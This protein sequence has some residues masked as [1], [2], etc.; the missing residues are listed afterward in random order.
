MQGRR[1]SK[2]LDKIWGL[3]FPC[4]GQSSGRGKSTNDESLTLPLYDEND[5]PEHAWQL[6]VYALAK[7]EGP[8]TVPVSGTC[9]GPI[10]DTLALYLLLYFPHPSA[11]HWFPSLHQVHAYPNV[12]LQESQLDD[13]KSPSMNAP[14]S[15]KWG[16]L[17]RRVK[18]IIRIARGTKSRFLLATA[19]GYTRSIYLGSINLKSARGLGLISGQTYTLLDLTPFYAHQV[20]AVHDG[21]QTTSRTTHG[22]RNCRDAFMPM[23]N[24]NLI[25]VCRELSE[26]NPPSPGNSARLYQY[27]LRRVTSLIWE[28]DHNEHWL[29]FK[30]T[31]GTMLRK[32]IEPTAPS[33]LPLEWCIPNLGKGEPLSVEAVLQ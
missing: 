4:L 17:Y 33:N 21:N 28:R 16:R 12:S 6:F 9:T 27:R 7:I 5:K 32:E 2:P 22:I 18:L 23:W 13:Q 26:W 25:I 3:F 20:D 1:A 19:P 14:L 15:I 30:E 8:R 31:I 29:P 10:A 24:T 11:E